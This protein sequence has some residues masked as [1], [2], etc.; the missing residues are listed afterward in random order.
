MNAFF[1]AL[2]LHA[3]LAPT[4]KSYVDNGNYSDA[5]TQALHALRKTLNEGH[6]SIFLIMISFWQRGIH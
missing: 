4:K 6:L 5:N 2:G 1:K 3:Y